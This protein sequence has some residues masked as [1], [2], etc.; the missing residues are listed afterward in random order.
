[1]NYKVLQDQQWH[2]DKKVP[3]ALIVTLVLQSGTFIWWAAKA[4][5]RLDNLER[6]SAISSPQIERIVKIETKM[7]S[8]VDNL[9]DV[10]VMLRI[11]ALTPSP[12]Q[13]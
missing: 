3:L 2:L 6:I 11:R 10:K 13:N 7:D 5:N 4:D 12:S 9:N 8:I 1:M